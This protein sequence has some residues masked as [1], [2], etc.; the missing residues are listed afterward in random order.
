MLAVIVIP[1]LNKPDRKLKPLSA[2]KSNLVLKVRSL[3]VHTPNRVRAL[4]ACRDK[5][6]ARLKLVQQDALRVAR[7]SSA[8]ITL[9]TVA[10][11]IQAVVLLAVF[12]EANN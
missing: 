4:P 1:R 6:P 9:K 7:A 5:V 3:I 12:A 2:P 10:F 11:V 8:Q